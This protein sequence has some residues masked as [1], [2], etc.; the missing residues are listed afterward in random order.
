MSDNELREVIRLYNSG[1]AAEACKPSVKVTA[2]ELEHLNGLKGDERSEYLKRLLDRELEYL[3]QL[4][5]HLH[6]AYYDALAKGYVEQHTVPDRPDMLVFVTNA[7]RAFLA[8]DSPGEKKPGNEKKNVNGRMLDKMMKDPECRGW[9]CTQWAKFLKC[10]T[11][12]V[13][14]TEAWK[15]LEMKREELKAGRAMDRHRRSKPKKRDD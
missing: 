13:V 6:G 3:S 5:D 15:E 1:G 4:P 10:S 11:P 8:A 9:T 12:S 7:G 14:A 2:R